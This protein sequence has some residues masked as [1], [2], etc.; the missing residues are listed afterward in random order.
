VQDLWEKEVLKESKVP[1]VKQDLQAR[2]EI[3][4]LLALLVLKAQLEILI[5]S[6]LKLILVLE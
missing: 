2:L 4:A 6:Y 3:Q 1:K 5:L